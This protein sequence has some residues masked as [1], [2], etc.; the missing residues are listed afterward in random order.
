MFAVATYL[1]AR[2]GEVNALRW[3]DVDLQRGVVLIHR[4]FNRETGQLKST[5][6]DTARRIPIEPELRPLLETMHRAARGRSSVAPVRGTD[7]KLSRQVRRCLKL[8]GVTRA[9]LFAMRDPT[10]KA[11][12]FHDLR[13]TG[14]TW[15]AVRGDDP[16][17]IKQR[18]GHASFSTT[19]GYIREAENLREGFGEVFPPLPLSLVSSTKPNRRRVSASVSAFGSVPLALLAQNKGYLVEAPGIE[20]RAE[21]GTPRQPPADREDPGSLASRHTIAKY[22][23]APHPLARVKNSTRAS[24]RSASRSTGATAG[25]RPAGSLYAPRTRATRSRLG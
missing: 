5:K 1:Y 13:A 11:M 21:R 17:K 23:T 24:W 7:R 9:D 22:R 4:S 2:A 10:R 20:V 12:T 25:A 3:E 19:E 15:C 6:S 14:V 8:A 18:A 16:L